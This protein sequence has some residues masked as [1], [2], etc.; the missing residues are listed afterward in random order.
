MHS[1]R[2][3]NGSLHGEAVNLEQVAEKY[4]TPLYVYSAGTILDH[5][6][7]LDS[8]LGGIDHLICYAVKANSNRAILKLLSRAGAGFDIVSGGEL[9]RVLAAGGDPRLCTFAGV[10]KSQEEIEYALEQQVL[11]FNVESEAELALIDRIARSK[12][13]R[14]PIAL[15]VNPDVDAGTHRYVSTGRDEN[16]F[17]IALDRVPEVYERAARMPNIAIRGVQMHIGSQITEAAPFAEAVTKITPLILKLKERHP[18]EFVSV[19]G[20]IGIVYESSFASG[21]GDWWSEKDRA[22][23]A[24]A[25]PLTIHD[26][27]AAILAP[28]RAIGLRVLL[29]PGRLLVG[30]AGVLLTRVRYIKEAGH[31]KFVIVDA[32]MNDLIRPALY[33]SYHEIVPVREAQDSARELVD[34]VGPVCESGD[35]FALDRQLPAMKEGD[36]I[37]LM[38]TGAYG[39]VM[40]SNYNSRPL[41]AEALVQ[42]EDFSLIR[43]RQAMD[44]LVRD[45][46]G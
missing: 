4:G 41:P 34:V 38:S 44:D 5:Y 46:C 42:G 17:G 3:H 36:L 33:Q 20:G 14:A 28:L 21:P 8:A 45:E 39:F 35:F 11:S 7:R 25:L 27:V 22:R 40:A 24:A 2:Y 23:A 32:G 6:R 29:E 13:S 37:A 31:K 9:F 19:G 18:L 1:F 30:N 10:G 43:R 16:K 15:R 26:Y 12:G